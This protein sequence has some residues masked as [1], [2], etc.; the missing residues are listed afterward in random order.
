MILGSSRKFT[1]NYDVFRGIITGTNHSPVQICT[2]ELTAWLR[3]ALIL[4][5]RNVMTPPLFG[6]SCLAES[7]CLPQFSRFK[8]Q[9]LFQNGNWPVQSFQWLFRGGR[10]RGIDC[11]TERW[12]KDLAHLPRA[13]PIPNYEGIKNTGVPSPS[14]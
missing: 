10:R 5:Q 8:N 4:L 1:T 11:G 6:V 9:G 14:S 13:P 2:L 3:H 12:R 7:L